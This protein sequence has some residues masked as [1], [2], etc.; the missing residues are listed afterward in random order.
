MTT[1]L[2]ERIAFVL[3]PI[4]FLIALALGEIPMFIFV[5]LGA[6]AGCALIFDAGR[7]VGKKDGNQ[8]G[9]QEG[10]QQCREDYQI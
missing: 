6:L 7:R 8:E 10:Y 4:F 5:F 2:S 9:Y 3:A 1:S